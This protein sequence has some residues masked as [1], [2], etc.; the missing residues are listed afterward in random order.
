M[1]R[2]FMEKSYCRGCGKMRSPDDQIIQGTSDMP[3]E[4]AAMSPQAFAKAR[5]ETGHRHQVSFDS[6][7]L[8]QPGSVRR[9][10][11]PRCRLHPQAETRSYLQAAQPFAPAAVGSNPETQAIA[12]AEA[13][14]AAAKAAAMSPDVIELMAAQLGLLRQAKMDARPLGARIDSAQARLAR[15][16]RDIEKCVIEQDHCQHSLQRAI[17]NQAEAVIRK[18]QAEQE[19]AE[20]TLLAG[21][22]EVP[23]ESDIE[24]Q[25][26]AALAAVVQACS[27]QAAGAAD[28]EPAVDEAG[29]Q[30][31][32]QPQQQPQLQSVLEQA[33]DVL[34]RSASRSRRRRETASSLPT[35]APAAT[36]EAAPQPQSPAFQKR[37]LTGLGLTPAPS[38]TRSLGEE[39]QRILTAGNENDVEE[40]E[41]IL[42]KAKQRRA[43]ATAAS[44]AHRHRHLNDPQTSQRAQRSH[45]R[46][47]RSRDPSSSEDSDGSSQAEERSRSP[48]QGKTQ[49]GRRARS[50]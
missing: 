49:C 43:A 11:P 46:R 2:N 25:A 47:N 38:G 5:H 13:A 36:R 37:L 3:V 24:T 9:I 29:K 35:L 4:V 18:Q 33:R 39:I 41:A 26:L 28:E 20:L 31:E 10:A 40:L 48:R 27:N 8:Q 17:A 15:A 34:R 12:H 16:G 22:L 19:L 50:S 6:S 23:P 42:Q 30:P 7:T 14:V 1:K 44:V 21:N 45:N 32:Q